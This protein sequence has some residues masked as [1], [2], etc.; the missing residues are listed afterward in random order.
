M[1]LLVFEAPLQEG[2]V[3][4]VPATLG[5]WTFHCFPAYLPLTFHRFLRAEWSRQEGMSE[6]R[7]PRQFGGA[8]GSGDGESG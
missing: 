8:L 3:G 4:S 5:V 2:L 1:S 7:W 6:H